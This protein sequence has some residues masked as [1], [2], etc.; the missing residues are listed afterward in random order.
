MRNFGVEV[1]GSGS[2]CTLLGIGNIRLAVVF[3]SMPSRI[4][5]LQ[6]QETVIF[7]FWTRGGF[8]VGFDAF[9]NLGMCEATP[10]GSVGDCE[11]LRLWST[12]AAKVQ[13]RASIT[14]A[15]LFSDTNAADGGTS[16]TL[17]S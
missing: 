1:L 10:G 6:R 7:C 11:A 14:A 15:R 12:G 8:D 13:D 4:Q 16:P 17:G 5:V 2:E 3:L 9:F